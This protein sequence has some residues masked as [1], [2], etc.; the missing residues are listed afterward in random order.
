MTINDNLTVTVIVQIVYNDPSD[1]DAWIQELVG[2]S[3]P[4]CRGIPGRP[5]KSWAGKVLQVWGGGFLFLQFRVCSHGQR[6]Q[7]SIIRTS[8]FY[9]E[10]KVV[11]YAQIIAHE[12][13]IYSKTRVS[14][15][16]YRSF[17]QF[18]IR[19]LCFAHD[20][21]TSCRLPLGGDAVALKSRLRSI[22]SIV[23]R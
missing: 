19:L 13:P 14:T 15:S 21:V 1:S 7:A 12:T 2:V 17:F 11:P 9:M 22:E 23:F 5:L 8:R 3:L 16:A 4:L 10:F 20:A 6:S 18:C